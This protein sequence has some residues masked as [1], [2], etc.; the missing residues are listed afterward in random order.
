MDVD[1]LVPAA[2]SAASAAAPTVPTVGDAVQLPDCPHALP[3][4]ALPSEKNCSD[5][6]FFDASTGRAA[7]AS[8]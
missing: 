5:R 4:T 1:A 6:I 7:R 2:A 3:S 8:G